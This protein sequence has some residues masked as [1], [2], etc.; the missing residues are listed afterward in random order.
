M[1]SNPQQQRCE[2]LLPRNK[3]KAFGDTSLVFHVS[4]LVIIS[5]STNFTKIIVSSKT[6]LCEELNIGLTSGQSF[7]HC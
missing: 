7:S 1:M 5:P 4:G 3:A 2:N 6:F